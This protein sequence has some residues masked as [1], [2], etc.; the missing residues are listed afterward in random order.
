MPV[1]S[2]CGQEVDN[3]IP[4]EAGMK[5]RMQ[6]DGS[7]NDIP[8]EVCK[9]CYDGLGSSL[10]KGAALRREA[11]QKEQN[12]LTLW[13][14]RVG[15][16]K[17]AKVYMNQKNFSEAAV[18]YEKYI[19]ILEI[20]YEKKSGD[21]TPELFN[22]EARKSEM[23]VIASVYW[24]LMRIYD[25]NSKYQDRLDKSAEKLAA[26][27]RFTPIYS[28]I[29]R[30]AEAQSRNARNPRAFKKFLS[31]SGSLR[32]RCFIATSAFGYLSP[33]VE[34][35]CRF[36]DDFLIKSHLGRL[37]I[38][39]YY[40]LS[41]RIADYIDKSPRLKSHIRYWLSRIASLIESRLFKQSLK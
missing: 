1:C 37:F 10:S 27:A 12:R 22:N 30:R 20:I 41:P 29:I 23:T 18:A 17:Q 4:V 34:I 15:L 6:A 33:E 8:V 24:D 7:L 5:L 3:L 21:L 9:S 26:F 36:R 13:R 25:N 16:V 28:S 39:T 38:E 40:L 14:S 19:R 35:L 2:R 32:P 31:L 11:I